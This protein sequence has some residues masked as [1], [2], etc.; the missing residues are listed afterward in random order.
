MDCQIKLLSL[1]MPFRGL[2]L[3]DL[4]STAACWLIAFSMQLPFFYPPLSNAF[5]FPF[6]AWTTPAL[7]SWWSATLLLCSFPK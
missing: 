3:L 4:G 2:I 5:F 7:E 6:L 1:D